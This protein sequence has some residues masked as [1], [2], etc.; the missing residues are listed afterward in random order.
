[1]NREVSIDKSHYFDPNYLKKERL[2]SYTEQIEIVK[3]YIKPGDTILEVGIGNGFVYNFLKDYLGFQISSVDINP[4]LNA[5]ITDNIINPSSVSENS[6]D[7]VTCFEVL[8]H[9]PF[10]DSIKAINNICQIA[11]K[12]V[13]IS[14]PDM[15]HFISSGFSLFFNSPFKVQRLFSFNRLFRRYEPYG[16][17]HFWEIG[18]RTSGVHYSMSFLK[19]NLFSNER[20]IE[21]YRCFEIPWHHYFVLKVT[22]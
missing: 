21:S 16:K 9:M 20:L 5:D 17:D 10:E 11:R 7:L 14:I 2:F 19:E 12:H 15:R 13:L 3:K 6:F 1:M 4:E 18:I 22:G 8:E